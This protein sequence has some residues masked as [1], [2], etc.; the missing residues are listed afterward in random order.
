MGLALAART[1]PAIARLRSSLNRKA[2]REMVRF[3]LT[4]HLANVAGALPPLLLPVLI[5]HLLSARDVAYSYV[6][7][8]VANLLYL[9]PV[10]IHTAVLAESARDEKLAERHA[11]RGILWTYALLL[12]ALGGLLA[13]AGTALTFFRPE[14]ITALPL[15][16]LLGFASLFLAL[17]VAYIT[18]LRLEQR[19]APLLPIY[20]GTATAVLVGADLLLP[21]LGLAGIGVAFLITQAGAS[22]FSVLGLLRRGTFAP[23]S[24]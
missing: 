17:N 22:A 1:V 5:L 10:S 11:R 16:D 7:R 14:Y 4:N 24:G 18:R 19:M 21:L 2:V 6:A 23:A 9:I 3:A 8:V 15:L 12:P 13:A 20:L